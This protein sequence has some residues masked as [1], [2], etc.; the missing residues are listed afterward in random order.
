LE[1][2]AVPTLFVGPWDPERAREMA[3]GTSTL[4]NKHVREG[5]VVK[6]WA[7]RWDDR[8]GRVI[9]KLHGEGFLLK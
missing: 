7:E 9:L 8:I 3:E 1:L 4:D 5:I 2:P 6:P